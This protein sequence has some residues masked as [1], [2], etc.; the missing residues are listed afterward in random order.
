MKVQALDGAQARKS[1]VVREARESCKAVL[2]EAEPEFL[3][4]FTTADE[5]LH[6]TAEVRHPPVVQPRI[7]RVD[8]RIEFLMPGEP[9]FDDVR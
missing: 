8:G 5:L 7:R 4:K 3:A 2:T 6:L 1:E 9:G